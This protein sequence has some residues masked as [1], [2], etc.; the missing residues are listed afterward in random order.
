MAGPDRKANFNGAI[1]QFIGATHL[2]LLGLA[3]T[4]VGSPFASVS[5][6]AREQ[7][8]F[9]MFHQFLVIG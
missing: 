7:L 3:G 4:C 2:T 9:G 1:A 6:A 8:P 5:S